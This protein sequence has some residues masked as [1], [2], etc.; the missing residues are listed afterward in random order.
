MLTKD[1]CLAI[2]IV[3]FSIGVYVGTLS[4]PHQS[5]YFPRFILILLGFLGFLL[6]V[7]EIRKKKTA[8]PGKSEDRPSVFQNP[9]FIK[10]SLM[11][12]YSVI[13]LLLVDWVGFFSTTIVSIPIMIWLLGVRKPSTVSV[14]TGVV[15]VF[16]Y[17]VFRMFLKVPFP[18]GLL[19]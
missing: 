14:A 3:L 15:V 9:A 19:F 6:F 1:A 10:V 7:K 17:I 4:Y 2:T 18:E 11:I 5:A 16:I 12:I 13:Y 8:I